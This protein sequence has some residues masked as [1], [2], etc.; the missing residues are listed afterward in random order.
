MPTEGPALVDI[1]VRRG[2]TFVFVVDLLDEDGA[3]RTDLA[4]YT[5]TMKIRSEKDDGTTLLATAA[6]TIDTGDSQA[7][8]TIAKTT[9][10]T[11]E[12]TT[13]RYDMVITDGTVAERVAQGRATLD[14][15]VT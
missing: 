3:A 9:T 15:N 8:A 10:A 11:Y 14:R 6:V 1:T 12:W 13:G 5:A 7:T 2:A 4:G